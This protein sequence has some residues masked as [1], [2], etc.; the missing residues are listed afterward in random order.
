MLATTDSDP[1]I[2]AAATLMANR[3]M[4]ATNEAVIACAKRADDPA[5]TLSQSPKEI[6]PQAHR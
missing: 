3:I 1:D 5:R 6:R 2:I 4:L